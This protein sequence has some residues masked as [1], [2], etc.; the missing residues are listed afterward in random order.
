MLN[1]RSDPS[2]II[3]KKAKAIKDNIVV[4]V[5]MFGDILTSHASTQRIQD[6]QRLVNELIRVGAANPELTQ[7]QIKSII[8]LCIVNNEFQY[9]ALLTEHYTNKNDLLVDLVEYPNSDYSL[10]TNNV[11]LEMA[12]FLIYNGAEADHVHAG[13]FSGGPSSVLY[14]AIRHISISKPD[15]RMAK[16]LID[17][18]ADV[19]IGHLSQMPLHLAVTKGTPKLVEEL[20]KKGAN[21][22]AQTEQGTTP[23]HIACKAKKYDLVKI[24]F[25]KG[26]DANIRDNNNF[27]VMDSSECRNIIKNAINMNV[28][29]MISALSERMTQAELDAE[30]EEGHLPANTRLSKTKSLPRDAATL[31]ALNFNDPYKVS[32]EHKKIESRKTKKGGKKTRRQKRRV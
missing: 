14:S 29:N 21:I 26:A 5:S 28:N 7:Q 12:N 17:A 16:L 13:V 6:K 15:D 32:E 31:I 2:L 27:S 24:L 30:I 22:N 3:V 19:N 4:R 23:L 9:F 18:G 8:R 25:E 11:K 20:I 10:E 1:L